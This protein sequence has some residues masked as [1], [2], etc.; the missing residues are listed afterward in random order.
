MGNAQIHKRTYKANKLLYV[1]EEIDIFTKG[2]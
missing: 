1:F 2:K